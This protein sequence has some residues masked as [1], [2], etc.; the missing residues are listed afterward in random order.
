[1]AINAWAVALLRYEA[2]VLKRTK[3]Q[4]KELDRKSVKTIVMYRALHPKSEVKRLYLLRAKG[5]LCPISCER[6]IRNEEKSNWVVCEELGSG[7]LAGVGTAEGWGWSGVELGLPIPLIEM[8]EKNFFSIW[9]TLVHKIHYLQKLTSCRFFFQAHADL[10]ANYVMPLL[11]S[12]IQLLKL[13]LF[14]FFSPQKTQFVIPLST[15]LRGP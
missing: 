13:L 4:L 12:C 7:T 15:S 2:G 9:L 5:Y 11:C 8:V 6:C 10:Y 1:M 3:E 14:F